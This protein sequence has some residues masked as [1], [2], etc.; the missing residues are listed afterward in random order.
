MS[1]NFPT[2][3]DTYTALVDTVDDVLAAHLNN[4]RDAVAA[5]EAKVGVDS[6]IVTTSHDYRITQLRAGTGMTGSSQ[7]TAFIP[8]S[9]TIPTNGF[10][11]KAANNPALASNTTLRWD[12]SSTGAHTFA[13]PIT[14]VATIAASAGQLDNGGVQG[15]TTG[16]VL[17][18][19]GSNYGRVIESSNDTWQLGRS[20]TRTG[21]VTSTIQWTGAGNVTIAAPSSGSTLTLNGSTAL[22]LSSLAATQLAINFNQTGQTGYTLYQPA[23]SGDF[24]INNG[25]DRYTLT[26]GGN[27]TFAAA[28]S[29]TT[30]T[31]NT[32]AGGVTYQATCASGAFNALQFTD[33]TRTGVITT[34][35]TF[36][37]LWGTTTAHD[38]SVLTNNSVGL[39]VTSDKRVYG[40]ALHNNAGAVTGTTNQ[41]IAS[42]TWGASISSTTNIAAN[43]INQGQWIRVGNVVSAS[44]SAQISQT[45]PGNVTIFNLSLP[46]ASNFTNIIDANGVINALTNNGGGGIFADPTNDKITVEYTCTAAGSTDFWLIFKYE[47]K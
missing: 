26:S 17:G 9:S 12:V 38:F 15:I 23:S 27:H 28:G 35:T 10:Y 37:T 6:S 36:G 18:G 16:L 14:A 42:G 25:S 47:V 4:P 5:I 21:A 34:N 13:G 31:S 43:T 7:A 19:L 22:Q 45:T 40:T 29:G 41:Y 20:A 2:T 3:L 39:V 33:G 44:L 8:T 24:R 46:I 1:T 30:L 11:L 32:T